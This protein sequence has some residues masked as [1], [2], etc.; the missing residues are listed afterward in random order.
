MTINL[1]N[2]RVV[3][4]GAARSGLAAARLLQS[5]GADVFVSDSAAPETKQVEREILKQNNIPSEFGGHSQKIESAE[6]VVL[7]PG[8]PRTI[9]P[10]QSFLQRNIPV[11]SEIEVAS[12][13]CRSPIIA[14]TG[15]NGKT[16]TTTLLGEMIKYRF[17][18][19]IVAG[20]IGRAF[21]DY[22]PVAPESKW[23]VLEVSSFQLETIDR[24]HPLIVI[25]LNLAPNHLDWYA[26][27]EEYV[28]AK[29]RIIKNLEKKDYLIYNYDDELICRK[30]AGCPA[31]KFSFSLKTKS[32][33]AYMAEGRIFIGNNHLIRT[34]DIRLKGSHNYQNAMAAAL[35]ASQAGI[36]QK[37]IVHILKTFT[38]VEHRLE[39]VTSINQVHFINDS[40]ATTV[41]SLAVALTSFNTPIVL[42]AGGKDKGSDY[43]KLIR[44][45][46]ENVRM[47]ILIGSAKEKINQAWR[48]TIPLKTSGN[49]E[50]AV[51]LAFKSARPGENILLSPACSSYDMFKDFEERGKRFKEIVHKLKIKYENT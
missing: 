45:L 46:K 22:L 25:L 37:G 32:A 36:S 12:W 43:T 9:K 15:S 16:T 2:K 18:E 50:E 4:M 42:I 5:Q 11:Y 3:I 31:E 7:S 48:D 8:I 21:S 49:L 33:R 28:N 19:A 23:V 41:E 20:N 13:F 34:A 39:Y 24:F 47:A 27:Y 6:L 17:P 26:S 1:K 51:E 38:G 10:I 30:I 40:K 44:L 14:V 35:A 29:L